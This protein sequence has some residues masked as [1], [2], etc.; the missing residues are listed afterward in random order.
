MPEA[1]FVSDVGLDLNPTPNYPENE[2]AVRDRLKLVQERVLIRRSEAR[3]VG[4]IPFG[5]EESVAGSQR[6]LILLISSSELGL[7]I[8]CIFGGQAA[9]QRSAFD[10]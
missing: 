1:S 10:S 3:S 8:V 4:T 6:V 7:H 9:F 5:L 2:R